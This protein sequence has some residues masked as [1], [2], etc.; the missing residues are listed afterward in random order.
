MNWKIRYYK[1]IIRVV[2]RRQPH[3]PSPPHDRRLVSKK[4]AEG[5]RTFLDPNH[6]E[7]A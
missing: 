3:T 5:N 6:Q 1:G 2:P 4:N 7:S